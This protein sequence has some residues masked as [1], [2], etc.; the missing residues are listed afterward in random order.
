M[1]DAARM[2][3]VAQEL[4]VSVEDLEALVAGADAAVTPLSLSDLIAVIAARDGLFLAEA[5]R[6]EE[7]RSSTR[8]PRPAFDAGGSAAELRLTMTHRPAAIS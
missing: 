5:R 8:A 4:M 6:R 3:I 7:T 2:S 1:D